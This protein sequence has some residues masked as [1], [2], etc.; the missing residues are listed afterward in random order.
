MTPAERLLA[1]VE[2]GRALMARER[3]LLMRGAVDEVARLGA[4]KAALLESLQRVIR[5]VRGTAGLRAALDGLIAESR[6][7][8]QLLHA[9]RQG[10]AAARRRI[11]A[12]L[13]T[14]RGAVAY[15]RDGS[16]IASREDGVRE[17]SRA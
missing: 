17:D 12:I 3:V 4:E 8:E 1:L 5:Q 6:R 2:D 16:V 11:A 7:N 15:D 14:R 13:A 9:A 10:V